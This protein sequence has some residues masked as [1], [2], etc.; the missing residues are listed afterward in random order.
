MPY[1]PR[2]LQLQALRNPFYSAVRNAEIPGINWSPEQESYGNHMNFRYN[3][4]HGHVNWYFRNKEVEQYHGIVCVVF[5]QNPY[6][7]QIPEGFRV[8]PIHGDWIIA[9]A[10]ID[11]ISDAIAWTV[12]RIQSIRR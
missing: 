8:H 4:I 1:T 5:K 7:P 9:S 2:E 10:E 3:E 12:A 11:N 6:E